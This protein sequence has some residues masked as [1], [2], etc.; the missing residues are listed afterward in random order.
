MFFLA[1]FCNPV[2]K[3]MNGTWAPSKCPMAKMRYGEYC[4]ATCATGFELRGP[5]T[6]R[7]SDQGS[8]TE[9]EIK[10]HIQYKLTSCR[11]VFRS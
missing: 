8:W 11:K 2:P 10:V 6:R 4:N 1:V 7:C 5:A 3:V 9:E